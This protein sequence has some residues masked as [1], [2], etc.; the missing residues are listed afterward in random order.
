[1]R[2]LVKK[3]KILTVQF[4]PKGVERADQIETSS[5]VGT[6]TLSQ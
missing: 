3:A 2:A 4:G 5:S 6:G 1:M